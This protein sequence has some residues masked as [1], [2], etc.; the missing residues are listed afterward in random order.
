MS[1]TPRSSRYEASRDVPCSQ[2][3]ALWASWGFV[4]GVLCKVTNPAIDPY[5]ESLV[6]STDVYLGRQGR[7]RGRM[8]HLLP[9]FC[10][11]GNL[12]AETPTYFQNKANNRLVKAGTVGLDR[13]PVSHKP[14]QALPRMRWARRS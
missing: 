1:T 2:G 8:P 14:S 13:K 6:M 4:Q 10:L 5:R 11:P 3:E 9:A 12:M 7:I